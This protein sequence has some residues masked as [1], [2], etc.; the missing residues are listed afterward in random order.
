M[1]VVK[2]MMVRVGADF[3]SLITQS[4]KAATATTGWAAKTNSGFRQVAAGSAGLTTATARVSRFATALKGAGA[5]MLAYFGARQLLNFAKDSIEAASDLA[6]VQNVVDVVFPNLSARV[7][8][9]AASAAAAYGLSEKMAKQYT[10]TYGAMAKA[11]GYSEQAAFEMSTT[12]TGLVG[13]V[14][15]FYNLDQETAYTKLKSVFTGETEALKDL[16]IVMT[17][18]ALDAYALANGFGKTT[19]QMTELEKVSL[20]YA[21]VQD[22]LT[23]AAGDFSRTA[24]GW[25]NQVRVLQLNFQSLKEVI[26]GG[27]ITLLTPFVRGLNSALSAL[28]KFGKAV[29]SVFSAVFGTKQSVSGGVVVEDIGDL[30]SGVDDLTTSE[31]GATSA[32]K[33]LKRQ[34][35]GFDEITKLGDTSSGSG[36]G[37]GSSVSGGLAGLDTSLM[38]EAVEQTT[39]FSGEMEKFKNFLNGLN[40]G[41]IQRAWG[42]LRDGAK[43]LSD[44]LGGALQWGLEHVLEPLAK[45]TIEEAAPAALDTLAAALETVSDALIILKPVWDWAWKYI[46]KPL[47]KAFGDAFVNGLNDL[48]TALSNLDGYLK[49]IR[50]VM[51]GKKTLGEML[52]SW[53]SIDRISAD[54]KDF[55]GIAEHCLNSIGLLMGMPNAGTNIISLK[56]QLEEGASELWAKFKSAWNSGSKKAVDI[57]N[58]LVNSAGTLWQNFKTAWGNSRAVQIWNSLVSSAGTLWQN[59]KAA[60]GSGKGVTIVNTLLSS[61]QELWEKFK[62]GWSGK[63]LGLKLTYKTDVSGVK[64]AV[65][66]ALGLSGWPTISFAARG[67]IVKAA[68]LLGNTVVGEDGKEAIVPLEN[69]TEWLD[70]VAGRITRAIGGGEGGGVRQPVVIYLT[71]NGRVISQTVIDDINSRAKNTGV[72]PLAA[73]M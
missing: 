23:S 4:K 22:Q 27:L 15:S 66:K 59:F 51:E 55:S 28:V 67:G 35:M 37:G 69:H 13:D 53:L 2:N 29:S 46:F 10:G 49:D 71:L 44:I 32:A 68:T 39:R 45:W 64:K 24:D 40:F 19:S 1:A 25:A 38:D 3:S 60:W 8:E 57:W 61:A 7:D 36:S 5:M 33:E 70:L 65:Y 48:N 11:F 14:A 21:F 31:K 63:T 56:V 16:G 12:L 30:S 54:L 73:W 17:Q 9:F 52:K 58:S 26:G 6:E 18:S 42:R 43:R 50:A 72:N 62:K 34:L 41:P 47:G 20:R